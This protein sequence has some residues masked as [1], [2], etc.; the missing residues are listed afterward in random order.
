MS[1]VFR[2]SVEVPVELPEQMLDEL[3]DSVVEV[4]RGWEPDSRNGW[5]VNV[6]SGTASTESSCGDSHPDDPTDLCWCRVGHY[7]YHESGT[8]VW[9]ACWG[10]KY[11]HS[12]SDGCF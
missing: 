10:C 1:K 4:A 3:F 2:I 9:G 7:G 8:Y 12:E 6:Y 5:D 11:A